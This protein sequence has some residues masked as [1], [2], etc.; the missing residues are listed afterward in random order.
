MCGVA[1]FLGIHDKATRLA[2]VESL[3]V[4]IDARGG[5]AAGYVS[6]H[7]HAIRYGRI[8]GEWLN[9]SGRF[10]EAAASLDA[11]T[12]LH[13][14]Y[15]TCGRGGPNEAHPF[16]IARSD[17]TIWGA[18]NGVV[19]GLQD[20]A[21]RRGRD[22]DVDSREVFNLLADNEIKVIRRSWGWGVLTWID[23]RDPGAI[24]VCK[25][26]EGADFEIVKLEKQGAVGDAA[27]NGNVDPHGNGGFVY[28][29]TWQILK[30]ALEYSGLKADEAYKLTA[31]KVYAIRESGIYHLKEHPEILLGDA[32]EDWGGGYGDD[33]R[34]AA[35]KWDQK[36]GRSGD[37]SFISGRV[38]GNV[39]DFREWAR[40]EEAEEKD[41]EGEGN[42]A[43]HNRDSRR[44]AIATAIGG[45]PYGDHDNTEEAEAKAAWRRAAHQ[46][47]DPWDDEHDS[48]P[49]TDCLLELEHCPSCASTSIRECGS[50]ADG[51]MCDDCSYVWDPAIEGDSS[52]CLSEAEREWLEMQAYMRDRDEK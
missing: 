33:W 46:T 14:R 38:G 23:S 32:K 1:G 48:S 9:A 41:I 11:P 15:A 39:Y 16:R 24:R 42:L 8:E 51:M 4:G 3:G 30:G 17:Y 26:T 43:G 21:K 36:W 22:Y 35:R 45:K 28:A 19:Y 29:S 31:G 20:S 13:A 6:I 37:N 12:M 49:G 34:A 44:Q 25:M 2:L 27:S 5:D 18:H 10:R 40:K 7:P 47:S 50:L 52:S